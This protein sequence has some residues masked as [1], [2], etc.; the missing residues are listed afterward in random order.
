MAQLDFKGRCE[1][2]HGWLAI[3]IIGEVKLGDV[4]GGNGLIQIAYGFQT[5]LRLCK[6]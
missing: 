2:A 1:T 5:M 6:V 4:E 3:G